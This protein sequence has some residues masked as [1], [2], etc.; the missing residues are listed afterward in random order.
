MSTAERLEFDQLC[1]DY[2]N[3][4]Y[5]GVSG[6]VSYEPGEK[7]TGEKSKVYLTYGEML[8]P[9]VDALIECMAITENDVFYDLG[10][11]VGKVGLQ[12]FLK[13]PVKKVVGIEYSQKR[14]VMAEQV[15]NQVKQ[16]FPDLFVGG[17]ELHCIQGNMLT[18]DITD[19]TIVYSCS[20]CFSEELL[21]NIG[22]L[23]ERCPN[24][25]YIATNKVIPTKLPLVGLVDVE[26]SWDKTKWHMYSVT[27]K[28]EREVTPKEPE[29]PE[30]TDEALNVGS[31]DT[32]P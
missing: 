31:E 16:E 32:S 20:T 3:A 30:I 28:L 23:L 15:Y 18:Q 9:S 29:V 4:L 27:G 11:G 26:C 8:Y 2:M 12:Y 17:R 24:L 1:Q 21:L 7:E 10:S 14:H 13:T 5:Q 6:F 22:E 19:A 25:R